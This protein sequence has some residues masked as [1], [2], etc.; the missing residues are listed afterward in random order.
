MAGRILG[1]QLRGLG[2]GFSRLGR[3]VQGL[4]HTRLM[5]THNPLLSTQ[6][7]PTRLA[8]SRDRELIAAAACAS[9]GHPWA[10]VWD[11]YS[12]QPPDTID[13][14]NAMLRA[15]ADAADLLTTVRILG[16]LLAVRP[17]LA[18]TPATLSRILHACARSRDTPTPTGELSDFFTEI[19][20]GLPP[21]AQSQIEYKLLAAAT[22]RGALA[23]CLLMLC[24]FRQSYPTLAPSPVSC[25]HIN[26]V[27][28]LFGLETFVMF[29][30][31]RLCTA[32][33]HHFVAMCVS[34][35]RLGDIRCH[36]IFG[37]TCCLEI[38]KKS[39]FP[40]FCFVI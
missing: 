13:G 20:H 10:P 19:F 5:P 37:T 2:A 9:R 32:R 40:F 30:C 35:S 17:P 25:I 33:G 3:I 14:Y 38:V 27:L 7:S 18:P 36:S 28:L 21:E 12:R 8:P 29:V 23:R 24:F 15:A 4:N 39:L 22:G 16:D 11:L 1:C 31:T 6:S 34:H 26:I